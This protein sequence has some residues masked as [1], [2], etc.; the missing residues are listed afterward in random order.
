MV[1]ALERQI[2]FASRGL[3][4]VRDVGDAPNKQAVTSCVESSSGPCRKSNPASSC[5]LPVEGC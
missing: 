3:V 2:G 4:I 5:R 1:G